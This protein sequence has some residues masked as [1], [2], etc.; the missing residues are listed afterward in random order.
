M[1][2]RSKQVDMDSECKDGQGSSSNDG[3]AQYQKQLKQLK[4]DMAQLMEDF[5]EIARSFTHIEKENEKQ[6]NEIKELFEGVAHLKEENEMQNIKIEGLLADF[7]YLTKEDE[8]RTIEIEYIT[9][10]S[11]QIGRDINFL[12]QQQD[13]LKDLIVN[14]SPCNFDNF[15]L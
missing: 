4:E 10:K 1:S 6:T 8:K 3:S 2:D 14:D 12:K 13:F 5:T 7:A 15:I 11:L 9:K